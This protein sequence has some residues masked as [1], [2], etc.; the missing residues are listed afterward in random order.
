[1]KR[2]FSHP[3]MRYDLRHMLRVLVHREVALDYGQFLRA[4]PL[5]RARRFLRS[6]QE[7]LARLEKTYG[8]PAE[9]LVAVFL[10]ETNLGAY[11]G[12]SRIA[13]VLASMAASDNFVYIRPHLPPSLMEPSQ[14]PR[15]KERLSRKAQWAFEELRSLL[16]FARENQLDPVAIRGSIFGAFGLCQFLPS[17]AELYGVDYD[18][19]GRV[20]LFKEEEALASMANYL[21]AHGWRRGVD[22]ETQAEVLLAYNPSRPY[23]DTVL[24]IVERLE[25]GRELE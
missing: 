7:K 5:E 19:D 22:R 11:P 12:R 8:V 1:V 14:V 17:S 24:A 20:D 4:A 21:R 18:G 10:V 13:Q 23:V 6:R 9:L 3:A 15:V 16:R 2:V 25:G